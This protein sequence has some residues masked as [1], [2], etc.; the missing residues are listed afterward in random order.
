MGERDYVSDREPYE[1]VTLVRQTTENPIDGIKPG[2]EWLELGAH[3][4]EITFGV[5]GEDEYAEVV[6][7]P[8]AVFLLEEP[9]GEDEAVMEAREIVV[10]IRD[11]EARPDGFGR[12]RSLGGERR[13]E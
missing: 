12:P 2:V 11:S 13:V 5:E 9:V 3:H 6:A 7:K 8:L 1:A 10:N 4:D